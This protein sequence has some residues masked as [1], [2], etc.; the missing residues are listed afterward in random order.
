MKRGPTTTIR[1]RF[2][3]AEGRPLLKAALLR[4]PVVASDAALADALAER[5][6]IVGL[7]QGQT[8]AKQ[9]EPENDLYFILSGAVNILVNGRQVASRSEGTHVGEMA[10]SDPVALRSA[11][12]VA[13]KPSVLA[14]ISE[15]AFSVIAAAHPDAWRRI[16][17]EVS[18]RL[19]ER[20][21]FLAQPNV[22]PEIFIGSSSEALRIARA[23][24]RAM[25]RSLLVP[26]LWATDVFKLSSTAIEDLVNE[27]ASCDFAVIVLAADDLTISRGRRRPSPRDN[28]IFEVGFFMGAIGRERT[29]LMT[30]RG[31]KLKIPTDI[32]GI[33]YVEYSP[34]AAPGHEFRIAS[35]TRRVSQAISQLGPK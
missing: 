3:G 10:V 14:K 28:A 12:V 16:A 35:A 1:S 29:F 31:A 5:V 2:E 11:T 4:Q 23:V 9:G 7:R 32:A 27:S 6:T 30:P 33:N 20:A 24:E 22:I 13:S 34:P 18:N 19:R 8:L 15:P 17:V 26:H 25:K 21:R